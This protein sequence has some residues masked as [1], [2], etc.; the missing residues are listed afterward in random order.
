MI[1]KKTFKNTIAT[2]L[3]KSGYQRAGQTWRKTVDN[4]SVL[5]NLQA[6]NYS[7]TYYVNIGLVLH[8]LT[9]EEVTDTT[10]AHI[11]TCLSSIYEDR[12]ADVVRLWNAVFDLE[13]TALTSTQH[14][15]HLQ[16][17]TK[18]YL[19]PVCERW[20]SFDALRHAYRRGDFRNALVRIEAAK[21]LESAAV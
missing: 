8:D 2:E 18:E 12:S 17:I 5:I 7:Q 19:V 6:S 16:S 20:L 1:E 13:S 3:S 11:Q 21:I 4:I 14:I 9:P 15:T 10:H